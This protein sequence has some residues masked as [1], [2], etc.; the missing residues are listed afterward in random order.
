MH[1]AF[2][3]LTYRR[4]GFV[5]ATM[6]AALSLSACGSGGPERG[7]NNRD[8]GMY[9][10]GL[11]GN[12]A[13]IRPGPSA[14]QAYSAGMEQKK[15]GDCKGAV[16]KLRPVA[17]LGPGYENAQFAL[18]ECLLPTGPNPASDQVLEAMMWLT[19]AAEGGWTEAQGRL[20]Y[21]YALGPTAQRNLDE[22]AYWLAV[23]RGN[24]SL[25]RIGFTPLEPAQD[26]AIAA[27]VGPDR[28][29]AA[30]TRAA[31]WQRKSWIPPAAAEPAPGPEMRG[32]KRRG[33]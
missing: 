4:F 25:A 12:M 8:A 32:T 29:K 22:A 23:Y 2:R 33:P 3:R 27:A 15:A 24:A 20:A 1:S 18:G 28:L 19:R 13:V 16:D 7:P 5:A 30:A 10:Q 6:T 14:N 17:N 11:G 26:A 9:V 31:S 21:V